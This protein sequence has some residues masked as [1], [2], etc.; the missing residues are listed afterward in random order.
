MAKL[1]IL[2]CVM[3]LRRRQ[4]GAQA[5]PGSE[6]LPVVAP[7]PAIEPRALALIKTMSDKLASAKSQSFTARGAAA[8]GIVGLAA[9]AAIGAAAAPYYPMS[10]MVVTPPSTDCYYQLVDSVNY[11]ECRR[12][13][14]RPYVGSNG[15]YYKIVPIP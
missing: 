11:Y 15:L 1:E 5:K 6:P 12:T 2:A 9:G 13:W 8:A 14:F 7:K 4:R 10:P 3:V